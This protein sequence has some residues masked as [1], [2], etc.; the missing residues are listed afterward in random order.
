MTNNRYTYR[1]ESAKLEFYTFEEFDTIKVKDSESD[2]W[3]TLTGEQST[4]AQQD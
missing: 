4:D 1:G 2:E 3:V